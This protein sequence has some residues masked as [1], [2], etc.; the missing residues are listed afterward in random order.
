MNDQLDSMFS[1][2]GDEA[3]Q[4]AIVAKVLDEIGIE[5][6]GKVGLSLVFFQAK[7]FSAGASSKNTNIPWTRDDGTPEDHDRH[8]NR[9]YAGSIERI[10]KRFMF[11]RCTIN[12]LYINIFLT[13]ESLF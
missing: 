1:E 11:L 5:M 3:E 13:A 12:I 6:N 2:P 7:S 10:A 8:G 4:D 9:K